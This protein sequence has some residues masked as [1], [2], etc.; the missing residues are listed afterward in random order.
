MMVI[1]N[2]N[3]KKLLKLS[4]VFLLSL[5]IITCEDDIVEKV[6]LDVSKITG[7]TVANLSSTSYVLEYANA[8]DNFETISWDSTDYGY[9]TSITYTL[10]IDISGDT[11][12]NAV[13][14]ATTTELYAEINIEDLNNVL[15]EDLSLTPEVSAAVQ[16]RVVSSISGT[17]ADV[18]SAPINVNIS[19][20]D[21]DIPPIY[22]LGSLQ[23]WNFANAVALQ[24]IAPL[25]YSG[26]ADFDTTA[27]FRFF[28][29]MDWAT[30]EQWGY[31]YFTGSIPAEF[32]D[33][34]DSDSNFNFT[35]DKGTYAITVDLND[36]SIEIEKQLFPSTL[37]IIGDDQAWNLDDAL[38]MRHV[39][40]GVFEAVETFGNGNIWRFFETPS[41]GGTQ[42]NYNTFINGTIDSDLSGTTE[43][44]ANFTFNG[45]TGIYKITVSTLDLTIDMEPAD[46]PTMYRVGGDNSW[47]FGESMTWI[48][49]EKFT[50]TTELTAGNEW[51]FFPTK[52]VWG[53]TRDYNA[54]K[55]VDPTLWSGPNGSDAN[56][57]NLV[58]GTYVITID[59][60]PGIITGVP[61][62]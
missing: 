15:V 48:R 41:W 44:D 46:M 30:G 35:G 38:A 52:D 22:L 36:K 28:E 43:G 21:P 18:N 54:F 33:N 27:V 60:V 8:N 5:L 31:S 19:P 39:G 51:R 25:M 32:G 49:G 34:G 61:A 47:T 23:G 56:F 12:A 29:L 57:L 6:I 42:W 37:Y 16:F 62:E 3:M 59:V 55:N 53:F 26:F 1:K 40:G 4:L 50:E 14:L 58:S 11:F 9:P 17:V 20:Y 7:G 45:T 2:K 10:Q 24:S 13:D